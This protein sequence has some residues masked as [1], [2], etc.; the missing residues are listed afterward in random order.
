MGLMQI[1]TS[2]LDGSARNCYWEY[3]RAW[4]NDYLSTTTTFLASCFSHLEYNG[5]SEQRPPVNNGQN[6]GVPMVVVVLR[7]DCTCKTVRHFGT[8][9]NWWNCW[10]VKVLA[11]LQL[12][13]LDV[14]PV[15]LQQNNI[16]VT[17][18]HP[19][20]TQDLRFH[21]YFVELILGKN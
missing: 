20:L 1:S 19:E 4:A 3:S 12:T 15:A 2:R 6:F 10:Q 8:F 5:T 7:F 13:R 11:T 17:S 16:M 18:F 9:H 21:Q 14:V